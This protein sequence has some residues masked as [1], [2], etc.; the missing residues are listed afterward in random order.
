MIPVQRSSATVVRMDKR[1]VCGHVNAKNKFGGYV[2]FRR[3]SYQE[4]G[5]VIL[6]DGRGYMVAEGYEKHCPSQSRS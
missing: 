4:D 1:I 2:G 5:E 6:D 3:F